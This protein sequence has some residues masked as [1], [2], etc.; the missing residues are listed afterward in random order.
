MDNHFVPLK[1]GVIT[2]MD[3][4]CG[5]GASLATVSEA[6]TF[7]WYESVFNFYGDHEI[8]A[9]SSMGEQSTG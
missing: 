5:V 6:I 9:V 7:G 2:D 3:A 8:K 4:T 1:D